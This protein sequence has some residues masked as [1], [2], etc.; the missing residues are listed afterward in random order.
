MSY[1]TL[2]EFA[3]AIVKA[4]GGKEL[5]LMSLKKVHAQGY[6]NGYMDCTYDMRKARQSKKKVAANAFK[7]EMDAIDDV[8][9][10][11]WS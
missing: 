7:G 8:M 1:K 5:I 3:E 9:K 6:N 4:G 2:E 11:K 10:S